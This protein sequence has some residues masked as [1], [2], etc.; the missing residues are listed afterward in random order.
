MRE[1]ATYKAFGIYLLKLDQQNIPR[2]ELVRGF[3]VT[4]DDLQNKRHR[5]DWS[6]FVA[7][8]RRFADLVGGREEMVSTGYLPLLAAPAKVIGSILSLFREPKG[9][10]TAMIKMGGPAFF[11]N[12]EFE[13]TD[14]G[15]N[16]L[17]V[18]ITIPEKYEDC[19]EFFYIYK[20]IYSC[21]PAAINL[22]YA[23]VEMELSPRHATYH[24]VL[25]PSMTLFKRSRV[26]LNAF[27]GA[28]GVVE[29][30]GSY[31]R[32]IRES[33]DRLEKAN[34]ELHEQ[35]LK[36]NLLEQV[37][38]MSRLAAVDHLAGGVGHEINNP[39]MI[40][41]LN[42]DLMTEM[43][44]SGSADSATMLER[45]HRMRDANL[46]IANIVSALKDIGTCDPNE[47]EKPVLLQQ[48]F[49]N[50]SNICATRFN[51]NG[52]QL[53]IGRHDVKISV[54]AHSSM[55]SH[56]LLY[57]LHNAFDAVM[58]SDERWIKIQVVEH[59]DSVRIEIVDS[60]PGIAPDVAKEMFAPFFTTKKVGKG[61][62]L[63]LSLAQKYINIHGSSLLYD[64]KSGPTRFSFSLE[65]GRTGKRKPKPSS[66]KRIPHETR[67]YNDR[68]LNM[69]GFVV[70]FVAAGMIG[71]AAACTQSHIAEGGSVKSAENNA[72]QGADAYST[73]KDALRKKLT[74]RQYDVVCENGTAVS[75]RILG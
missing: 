38:N 48:I 57:L 28:R 27:R 9:L 49:E 13:F 11:S 8:T 45:L 67:A 63:G 58:E 60:G 30:L 36:I 42:T 26:A 68:T 59:E 39:L 41:L 51:D 43:V 34:R 33:Y 31:Q 35:E 73:K 21:L 40:L 7:L 6:L 61:A 52:V 46:R 55:L 22:L 66:R 5:M 64:N 10:Y 50:I 24:I 70:A 17:R 19:P 25:P 16:A 1:V 14:A 75:K 72:K 12:I 29:E 53:D 32:E 18:D 44:E 69:M 71:S 37:S 74:A 56:A 54:K 62:G 47:P 20:G 4:L 15:P 3:P 65:R 2:S 23:I